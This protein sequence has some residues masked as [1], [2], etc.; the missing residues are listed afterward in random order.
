MA[1]IIGLF[2][3]G[4]IQWDAYYGREPGL[5]TALCSV[6]GV[7]VALYNLYRRI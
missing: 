7:F 3:Y 2:V 1:L 6:A 5:I 4:G